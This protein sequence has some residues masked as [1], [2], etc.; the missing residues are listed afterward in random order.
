MNS[1]EQCTNS[2][3]NMAGGPQWFGAK[4]DK[5]QREIGENTK[6]RDECKDTVAGSREDE[7]EQTQLLHDDECCNNPLHDYTLFL[8]SEDDLTFN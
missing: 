4:C 5:E 8:A 7:M 2:D 6:R 3:E 1:I